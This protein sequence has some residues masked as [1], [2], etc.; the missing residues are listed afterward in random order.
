[1]VKLYCTYLHSFGHTAHPPASP[2]LRSARRGL[3]C[4]ECRPVQCVH[5][6]GVCVLPCVV[7]VASG[8][9]CAAACTVYPFRVCWGHPGGIGPEARVGAV[10]P[11]S[12]D[13]NKKALSLPTSTPPSQIGTHLIVQVSKFSEK[14]K[15]AP[16]P[17]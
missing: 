16:F 15:K 5:R 9:V 3:F 10:S 7:C 17:V 6:P 13:Q 4:I 14:Y 1:M 12:S 11:V 2:P 8:T